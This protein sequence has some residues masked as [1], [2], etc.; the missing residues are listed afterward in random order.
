MGPTEATVISSMHTVCPQDASAGP[1]V[2]IGHA[3]DGYEFYIL[4]DQLHPLTA[5]NPGELYIAGV[6]ARPRL[7]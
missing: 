2:T 3:I 6:G 1:V 7:P 5:G 4:D